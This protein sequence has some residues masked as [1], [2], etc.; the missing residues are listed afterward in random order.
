MNQ[1]HYLSFKL[2]N[3]LLDIFT[4]YHQHVFIFIKIS[5]II[6]HFYPLI[7]IFFKFNLVL[8]PNLLIFL[9]LLYGNIPLF[10]L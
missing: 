6:F 10:F 7:F 4:F 8:Y 2:S 3:E 9:Y 5:K 1:K